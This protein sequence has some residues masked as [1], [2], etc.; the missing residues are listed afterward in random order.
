LHLTTTTGIPIAAV[1]GS[2]REPNRPTILFFYGNAG[3][4]AWSEGEF[5][6]FRKLDC[7]VL[8]PDLSGFGASGG[9]PSESNFYATA[10]AA[11]D[12]LQSRPEIDKNKIIVVG[13]SLGG[14]IAIDLASRKTVAG[15]ATFNAFTTLPAMA[16]KVLPYIPTGLFLKYKFDNLSKIPQ[17]H[18]PMFIC[19]GKMDT[20]V[21]P[22]MSDQLA[23]AAGGPVTRLVIPTADHNT[24]FTAEPAVLWDAMGKWID[25]ISK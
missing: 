24:I 15:L 20:L 8:I 6:H 7:N 5:D 4:V 16:R 1:F 23:A 2:A 19:N 25:M 13:W 3:S 14:G 21:P 17:I 18:C 11:W 22:E 10:D 9:K 12:Y